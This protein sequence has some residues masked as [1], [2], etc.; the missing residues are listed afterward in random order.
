M[1]KVVSF[2]W[3]RTNCPRNRPTEYYTR[4]WDKLFEVFPKVY[5]GWKM[6]WHVAGSL[7]K[8]LEDYLLL[9][10]VNVMIMCPPQTMEEGH[11]WRTMP[12]WNPQVEWCAQNDC[13]AV[14]CPRVAQARQEAIEGNY[15][16]HVVRDSPDHSGQML[17]GLCMWH[18]PKVRSLY[19]SWEEFLGTEPLHDEWQY[20]QWRLR[21]RIW[22]KLERTLTHLGNGAERGEQDREIR[23][24]RLTNDPLDD[25]IPIAGGGMD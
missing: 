22:D 7:L 18:C 8:D 25:L 9:P 6:Q 4:H 17:A 10:Y 2:T 20:N 5:P 12:C 24:L 21:D 14:P 16:A 1:D 3:F 13:D 11:L 15:D 19:G 23:V